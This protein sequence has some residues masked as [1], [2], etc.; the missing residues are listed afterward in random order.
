MRIIKSIFLIVFLIFMVI[1]CIN[2][3]SIIG[4][5]ILDGS[6]S[7]IDPIPIPFEG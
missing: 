6:N 3:G 5:I 7:Y 2:L 1:V 4:A